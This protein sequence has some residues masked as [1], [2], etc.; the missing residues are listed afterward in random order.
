MRCITH[1]LACDCR[2]EKMQEICRIIFQQHKKL[3]SVPD[4]YEYCHCKICKM[5][6]SLYGSEALIKEELTN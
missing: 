2:E 5:I 6:I 3:L 4:P 1:H